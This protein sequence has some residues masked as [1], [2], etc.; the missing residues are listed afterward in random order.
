MTLEAF[1]KQ[2]HQVKSREFN[3][4]FPER[5]K[6]LTAVQDSEYQSLMSPDKATSIVYKLFEELKPRFG[7]VTQETKSDSRLR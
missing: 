6:N 1:D 2:S 4:N 3:V 5:V 7:I